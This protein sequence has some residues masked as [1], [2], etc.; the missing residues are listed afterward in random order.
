MICPSSSMMHASFCSYVNHDMSRQASLTPQLQMILPH[1][2]RL[3][4]SFESLCYLFCS[5]VVINA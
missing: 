2:Q 5:L 3:N 4:C 1:M